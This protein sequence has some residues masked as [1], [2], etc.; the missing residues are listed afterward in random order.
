MKK[1][2]INQLAQENLRL[3]KEIENLQRK[4]FAITKKRV[5]ENI[6]FD[7]QKMKY[8]KKIDKPEREIIKLKD[9]KNGIT[10]AETLSS[11]PKQG[12]GTGKS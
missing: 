1:P 3:I 7:R 10:L 6:K 9:K 5:S 11:F 2:D 12:K 8:E 4:H